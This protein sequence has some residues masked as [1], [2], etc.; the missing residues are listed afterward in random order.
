MFAF[1][2]VINECELS[3]HYR[4]YPLPPLN[5]TF[6]YKRN[7]LDKRPE[8]RHWLQ[9]NLESSVMSKEKFAKFEGTTIFTAYFYPFCSSIDRYENLVKYMVQFFVF[10]DHTEADWGDV[11]RNMDEANKIWGQFDQMLDK[12]VSDRNIPMN[13]WKPYVLA[14]YSVFENIFD[15]FNDTQKTRSVDAWK[16]YMQGNLEETQAINSG[17]QFTD[18]EQ[19][20]K[21]S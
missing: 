14:M 12:L 13:G 17:L 20:I 8:I 19:M 6:P 9:W 10:D 18:I 16:S 7:P 11:A 1:P 3:K 15:Q 21:V 5:T 4:K 2:P